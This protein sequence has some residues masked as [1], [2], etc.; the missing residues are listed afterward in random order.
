MRIAQ[1]F[2]GVVP[3]VGYGGI[4]RMVYWLSEELVSQGHE[5][6]LISLKEKAQK[7]N[8][9]ISFYEYIKDNSVLKA[10]VSNVDVVHFHQYP[11]CGFNLG[12][13]FVI[14]E[15]GNLRGKNHVGPNTVFISRSHANN[16]NSPV[17]VYNGIPLNEYPVS[18][19]KEDNFLFLAKLAWRKKNAKT[20]IHLALDSNTPLLLCGGNLWG[21]KK[22]NG[23]WKL[24]SR[25]LGKKELLLSKGNVDGNEKLELLQKTGLLF[26]IV[27]WQ[28]PFALAPH[29]AMAT[30]TPVL[31]SPNGALS[32]Y[33]RHGENGYL[34]NNYQQ[35]LSSIK[36]HFK[37]GDIQRRDM[38]ESARNSAFS[39]RDSAMNYL[40]LYEKVIRETYLYPPDKPL[41]FE[42]SKSKIIRKYAFL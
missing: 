37:L 4:E 17:Y 22:I 42:P 15:H 1:I 13:P 27:N 40:S 7:L 2:N 35:A 24:S 23:V 38:Y 9:K 6:L 26:Y 19:D 5:V 3:P 14:T 41:K 34:V 18:Y 8:P 30:G 21:E 25:L 39:I 28:E 20:A 29:E 16:H 12:K 11:E 33:I 32:E 36:S 10:A 31:A